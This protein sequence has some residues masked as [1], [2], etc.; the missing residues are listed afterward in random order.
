MK[1]KVLAKSGEEKV[2]DFIPKHII[3]A[4]YTGRDQ[5]AVQAH[6]DELKEEGIPAPDKTPVYFVKFIDKI[7]QS[8]GFEVLDETDHSGEAKF[9]LFFAKDE[10]Y[11]GVGSDHTDRKLETV[12]IPK[13]KRYIPIPSARNFG[14]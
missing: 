4:G 14:S 2:I 13:A 11:V 10:I 1:F 12:D 3:N 8:G 6:I 9:A 7:T 5:A